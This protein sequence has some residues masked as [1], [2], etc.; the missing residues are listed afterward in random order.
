MSILSL[1]L[2]TI[3]GAIHLA[4]QAQ[5]RLAW[6][7]VGMTHVPVKVAKKLK[8]AAAVKHSKKAAE[9]AFKRLGRLNSDR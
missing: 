4:G 1:L 3:N 8:N 2:K 6:H 9:A 5:K 7:L